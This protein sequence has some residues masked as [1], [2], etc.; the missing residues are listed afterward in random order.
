MSGNYMFNM[1]RYHAVMGNFYLG[2]S[3]TSPDGTSLG[4]KEAVFYLT[5]RKCKFAPVLGHSVLCK[6]LF[7]SQIDAP[8][9]RFLRED[10]AR[11]TLLAGKLQREGGFLG[12]ISL[13][14]EGTIMFA[15]EPFGFIK[16]PL[17]NVQLHE[18]KFEHAF[19]LPMTVGYRA[20]KMREAAGNESFLS[21]FSQRRDGDSER[22]VRVSEAAYISGF[23]DTSDMEAA[24]RLGIS[25]VGTMAHYLVESFIEYQKKPEIDKGTR[26]PKHFERVAFE[27]WLDDNPNG[28]TLLICTYSYKSGIVHA[29]QAALSTPERKKSFKAIRYDSDAPA[30]VI[31]YCRKILDLNGFKDVGIVVTGDMDEKWIRTI[32]EKCGSIKG[33]GV[34][35]RMAAQVEHVAGVIFKMTQ[36]AEIP[37]LKTSGKTGGKGTLPGELQVWRAIDSLGKYVKDII[38]LVDEPKPVSVD[39]KDAQPLIKPFWGVNVPLHQNIPPETLKGYVE[40]QLEKFKVPLEEYPVELSPKLSAL[41]EEIIENV[42]DKNTYPEIIY[43]EAN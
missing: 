2:D 13:V 29:I 32:R 23:D 19:D 35:T 15:G 8:H 43:P 21:V 20:I 34:G 6:S 33:Y 40:F 36:M 30:E 5:Q 41:K 18:V 38:C 42:E 28:T 7:E 3:A 12:N 39:F 14:L 27:R 22:S 1:D 4:R 11:L 31:C 9:A 37:I 24:F 10:R 17:W 26:K 25:D 16:G